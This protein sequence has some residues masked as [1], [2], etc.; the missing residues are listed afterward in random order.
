MKN[1][2]DLFQIPIR[3]AIILLSLGISFLLMPLAV[4]AENDTPPKTLA[5][6]K[7]TIKTWISEELAKE[8]NKDILKDIKNEKFKRI[9]SDTL[10]IAT[11]EVPVTGLSEN[12]LPSIEQ[13]TVISE[14]VN[15][16]KF[17]I[18]VINGKKY[19]IACA[20]KAN[21]GENSDIDLYIKNKNIYKRLLRLNED[22][23]NEVKLLKPGK[24]SPI[25][26]LTN[27]SGGGS[28]WHG[29]FYLLGPGDS[30]KNVLNVGGWQGWTQ[31]T[32]ID[33]SGNLA[34][35][36]GNAATAKGLDER[37]EKCQKF[38]RYGFHGPEIERV[39]VNK[40]DGEKFQKIGAFYQDNR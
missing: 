17:N 38:G 33:N 21:T 8:P 31:Y 11:K 19:V 7:E 9:D 23:F 20:G 28:G 10:E 27:C 40:W 29:S 36:N 35:I 5:C 18:F 26:L 39:D 37:L 2:K 22:S 13:W 3:P 6:H 16:A 12:G 14:G 24:S 25:F 32:D 34:I 15:F 1:S 4:F 30:C